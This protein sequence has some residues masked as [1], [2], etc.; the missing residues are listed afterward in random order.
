MREPEWRPLHTESLC[1]TAW[2]REPAIDPLS[3]NALGDDHHRDVIG[4]SNPDCVFLFSWN[5]HS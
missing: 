4:W 5:L 2:S 1:R 3:F